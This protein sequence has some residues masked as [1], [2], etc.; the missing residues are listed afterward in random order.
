MRIA[1]ACERIVAGGRRRLQKRR[2]RLMITGCIRKDFSAMASSST[3]QCQHRTCVCG[4]P[5]GC[6]GVCR[7]SSAAHQ[8]T[9]AGQ[10]VRGLEK[11]AELARSRCA[12]IILDLA[13]RSSFPVNYVLGPGRRESNCTQ[14]PKLKGDTLARAWPCWIFLEIL[15]ANRVDP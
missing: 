8:E 13:N 12:F 2:A 14:C 3:S 15:L 5:K 10:Q 6:H 1:G 9:R 4:G 7:R 11:E